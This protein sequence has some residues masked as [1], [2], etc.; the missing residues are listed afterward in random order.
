MSDEKDI[1]EL[2]AAYA[3]TLDVDD[4]EGCLEL[5]TDDGEFQV[6][7]KTWAGEQIR[8]MFTRA[9]RGMHLCGGALVDLHG[10]TATARTQMLFI[11]SSTHELRPALYDDELVK[12]EGHW[13]FRRRR[14]QFI[15]AE[16]LSDRPQEQS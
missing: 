8:E 11:D 5:F 6:Y 9:P 4:L 15:T 10:E 3:L 7:G 13:R 1:R 16:G 2:I 12:S 14:C